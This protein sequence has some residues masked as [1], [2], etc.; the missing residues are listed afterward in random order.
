[1][2]TNPNLSNETRLNFA[3]IDVGKETLEFALK[4]IHATQTFRN[5]PKSIK[6]LVKHLEGIA[7]MGAIV[8]EVTGR[9]EHEVALALC[10]AGLSVMVINSR[11]ARRFD[12]A[13]GYLS[14]TD[15]IDARSLA[16]QACY[17]YHT[18]KREC[19][20]LRLPRKSR[21]SRWPG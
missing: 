19:L 7:H 21:R 5:D 20:F 6:H 11:Q 17:L 4:G 1:M 3:G 8:M 10:A 12:E 13:A 16:E 14:K 9:L 15:A 18:D 2:N